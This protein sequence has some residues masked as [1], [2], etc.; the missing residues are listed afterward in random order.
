MSYIN[1]NVMLNSTSWCEET[2]WSRRTHLR[3]KSGGVSNTLG[4]SKCYRNGP[5]NL[6]RRNQI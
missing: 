5:W 4:Y 2:G 1:I 6:Q 3:T